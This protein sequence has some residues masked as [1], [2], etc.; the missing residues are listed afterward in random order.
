MSCGQLDI[1]SG[2]QEIQP[3]DTHFSHHHVVEIP[4]ENRIAERIAG[5]E[6]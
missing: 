3:E 5:T 1:K 4:G 2:G 6:S